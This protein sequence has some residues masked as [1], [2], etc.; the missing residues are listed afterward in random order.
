MLRNALIFSVLIAGGS[1]YIA[2]EGVPDVVT[3]LLRA[4]PQV[5]V[6]KVETT[7]AASSGRNVRLKADPRGHYVTDFTINGR[8]VHA[9]VDTGASVV[10][11]NRS[12]A[13]RF[14]II[15]GAEDFTARVSTANGDIKAA[16]V[17]LDKVE[18]GRIQVRD[19]QAM[20]LEDSALSSVLIG[21]SFL[22]NLR[23]SVADNTLSLTQ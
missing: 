17:M 16:P 15:V 5:T 7:A 1:A 18:I 21:M 19:V 14:G 12:T 3:N 13:K 22:R 23:F 10:A 11:I 8:K 9:M 2:K 4:Q 20:V 6:A